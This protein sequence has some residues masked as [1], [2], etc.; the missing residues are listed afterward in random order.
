[1]KQEKET[2]RLTWMSALLALLAAALPLGAQQVTAPGA[3]AAARPLALTVE[4]RTALA[5]AAQRRPRADTRARP[6]DVLRYR[7]VF[8]NRSGRPVRNVILDSP[9]PAGLRLD[10]ASVQA[11]RADARVEYSIDGGRSWASQPLEDVVV[12]GNTV[13]RPASPERYTNVRWT[14]AGLV[15][16]QTVVTAQF[17]AQVRPARPAAAGENPARAPD[18]R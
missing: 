8:T 6:G 10:V 1:M 12:A 11:T 18:G 7:L 16:P 3:G 17:E 4:N 15:A 2:M 9:I 14:V 13:R 5:E